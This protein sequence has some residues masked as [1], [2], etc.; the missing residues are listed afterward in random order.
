MKSSVGHLPDRTGTVTSVAGVE[1]WFVTVTDGTG[2][3]VQFKGF[4]QITVDRSSGVLY[5]ATSDG[6]HS[7]D[8]STGEH[9]GCCLI[10]SLLTVVL[11]GQASRP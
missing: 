5:L 8:P 3:S 1:D 7:F 6:A 11:F 10:F 9:F 4:N 2:T